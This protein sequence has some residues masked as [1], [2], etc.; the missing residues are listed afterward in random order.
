VGFVGDW[1]TGQPGARPAAS[2]L[3]HRRANRLGA[4]RCRSGPDARWLG[5]WPLPTAGGQPRRCTGVRPN[6]FPAVGSENTA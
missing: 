2:T 3:L 4:A 6:R 1:L 5:G